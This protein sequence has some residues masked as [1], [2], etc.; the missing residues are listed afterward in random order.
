[1]DLPNED[2]NRFRGRVVELSMR[3]FGTIET[4][5]LAW[6]MQLRPIKIIDKL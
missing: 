4:I 3:T 2:L 5:I 1:M 6:K